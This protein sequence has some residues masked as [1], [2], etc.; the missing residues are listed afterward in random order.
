MYLAAN[1][2]NSQRKESSVNANMTKNESSLSGT[3]KGHKDHDH[4]LNQRLKIKLKKQTSHHI[5]D[6]FQ[7]ATGRLA[8]SSVSNHSKASNLSA[9]SANQQF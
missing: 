2:R 4:G 3:R 1:N 8:N 5:M 9:N 7:S 6:S